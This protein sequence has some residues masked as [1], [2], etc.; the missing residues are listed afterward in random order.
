MGLLARQQA[1]GGGT[2][3]PKEGGTGKGGVQMLGIC[4]EWG[5]HR[6][7]SGEMDTGKEGGKGGVERKGI[8]ETAVL[9]TRRTGGTCHPTNREGCR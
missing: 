8:T 9:R 7:L 3:Y 4:I 6:H 5:G 2:D 1:T